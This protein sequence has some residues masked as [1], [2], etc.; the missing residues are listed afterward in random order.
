MISVNINGSLVLDREKFYKTEAYLK[1]VQA[2]S[3]IV[4]NGYSK[5]K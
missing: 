3:V 1:Q 4:K 5:I 2:L